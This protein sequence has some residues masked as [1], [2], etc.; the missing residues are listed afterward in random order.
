LV[1]VL[2]SLLFS[3]LSFVL[4][5]LAFNLLSDVLL[6]VLFRVFC[7]RNSPEEAEATT[8]QIAS[9][10]KYSSLVHVKKTS[11]SSSSSSSS[12]SRSSTATGNYQDLVNDMGY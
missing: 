3:F 10:L 2:H 5:L 4:S 6:S 11:K 8:E 1:H 7:I 9:L 12:S